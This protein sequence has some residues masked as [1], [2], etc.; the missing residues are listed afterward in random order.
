MIKPI[1]E[2]LSISGKFDRVDKLENGNLRVIDFKTGKGK[3]GFSQLEFYKL[4]AELNF[5]TKVDQVSYYYL[6]SKEIKNFDV[7]EIKEDEIKNKVLEKIN[8]I[9]ET[10]EF[11][12][13]PNR[14]CSYCDFKEICPAFK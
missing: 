3:N 2:D 7:S 4:L 13:N 9:K 12:P 6:N 14:L 1:N 10:R 8:I 5:N 11:P